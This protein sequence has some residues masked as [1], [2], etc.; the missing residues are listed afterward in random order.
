[1]TALL[2]QA[3][4]EML[5]EFGEEYDQHCVILINPIDEVELKGPYAS[6]FSEQ[7]G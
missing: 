1:M 4:R 2:E 5:T 7:A 3:R 6:D